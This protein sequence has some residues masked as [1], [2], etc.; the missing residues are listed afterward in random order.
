[1]SKPFVLIGLTGLAATGKDTLADLLVTHCGF[2]KL[3]FA[4]KLYNEI[5]YA[6]GVT[7]PMLQERATKEHPISA[8]RLAACRD[9]AFVGR[10]VQVFDARGEALEMQAANSPRRILQLW[11]TEYRR[12][13]DPA[14]WTT[15][16]NK[17]IH[18]QTGTRMSHRFVI[19]DCRFPNEVECIRTLHGG[20]IWQ[21][22]RPGITAP[23]SS[24][25]SDNAGDG[26][27]PD[28]VI[29]NDGDIQHL[30]A[31]A[32]GA[33]LMHDAGLTA[34]DITRMGLAHTDQA[35]AEFYAFNT[36]VIV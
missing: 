13:Q 8:L 19:T 21:V 33:F 11:G 12:A 15:P 28:R 31:L 25:V 23:A 7:V 9:T 22:T 36:Q 3:A 26:F 4:D 27:K 20:K 5:A 1:M 24:H 14:Y 18:Y 17:R 35:A 2:Y 10:M 6:F 29:K 34:H 32:L 30:Q 16:V